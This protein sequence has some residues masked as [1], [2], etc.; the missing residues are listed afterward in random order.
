[1]T[2]TQIPQVEEAW[3]HL[4]TSPAF[5]GYHNYLA[6]WNGWSCP[7]FARGEAVRLVEYLDTLDGLSA[8]WD[9]DVV[10]TDDDNQVDP[11][12]WPPLTILDSHHYEGRVVWAIGS[13][14]WC[15][16]DIEKP[17]A[18]RVQALCVEN[19]EHGEFH[20]TA[21]I[22]ERLTLDVNG[23]PVEASRGLQHYRPVHMNP[24][25]GHAIV[26]PSEE[27]TCATCGSKAALLRGEFPFPALTAE[28]M[29]DIDGVIG[30]KLDNSH[31][32]GGPDLMEHEAA[33]A[34][35]YDCVHYVQGVIEDGTTMCEDDAEI[36]ARWPNPTSEDWKV[37]IVEY[38]RLRYFGLT[39]DSL[40]P[41]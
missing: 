12:R 18:G 11:D 34:V 22:R 27:W 19:V 20:A 8:S 36:A 15:W 23:M 7:Y 14:S 16:N 30:G 5:R 29:N 1:M 28:Q 24:Q 17:E 38:V 35:I 39:N 9:G 6:R 31:D 41:T 4:D 3:F 37:P 13:H 21:F 26:F 40:L 25:A 2:E 10:V 33:A 32:A